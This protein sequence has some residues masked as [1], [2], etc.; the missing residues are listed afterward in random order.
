MEVKVADATA[1]HLSLE[2]LTRDDLLGTTYPQKVS[3]FTFY[4]KSLEQGEMNII[5]RAESQEK[6]GRQLT[7]IIYGETPVG[8]KAITPQPLV[9]GDALYISFYS[10]EQDIPKPL[11]TVEFTVSR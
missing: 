3:S 4:K 5:W 7:K 10:N 2:L 6:A 11:G 9:S 1:K 8:F